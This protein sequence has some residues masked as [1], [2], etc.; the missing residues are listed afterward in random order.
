CHDEPPHGR[1]RGLFGIPQFRNQV[2]VVEESKLAM[3]VTARSSTRKRCHRVQPVKNTEYGL[4]S[5]SLGN[6]NSVF[7][8]G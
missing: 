3:R 2:I 1:S 6:E 4:D 7:A 8:F 5:F